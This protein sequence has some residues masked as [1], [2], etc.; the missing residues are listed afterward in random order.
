MDNSSTL[1]WVEECEITLNTIL[2]KPSTELY[3][4]FSD[5][6][7]L[8]GVKSTPSRKTFCRELRDRFDLDSGMRQGKGGK[9]YFRVNLD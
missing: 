7:K 8:S 6:C 9:W 3:S 2:E 1:S 5:W 4:N